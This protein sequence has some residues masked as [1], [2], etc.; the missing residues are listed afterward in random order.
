LQRHHLPSRGRKSEDVKEQSH[1]RPD[2]S[3][4]NEKTSTF[5]SQAR[6]GE[7][8]AQNPSSPTALINPAGMDLHLEGEGFD[9]IDSSR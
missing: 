7:I 3:E 8:G 1:R 9:A 4:E 2:Q 6:V 5:F